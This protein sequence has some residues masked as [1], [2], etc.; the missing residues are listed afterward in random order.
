MC[1]EESNEK[2][3]KTACCS[4]EQM[5][6]MF[7]MMSDCGTGKDRSGC[8]FMTE[9]MKGRSCCGPESKR[10]T[11]GNDKETRSDCC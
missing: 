1:S 11:S 9:V 5:Q 7:Q 8:S 6:K 3:E 10:A 2:K 4:P